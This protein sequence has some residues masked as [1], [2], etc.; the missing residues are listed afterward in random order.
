[1][2]RDQLENRL[3]RSFYERSPIVVAQQLLGKSLLRRV[4]QQWIGGRI[5]ETEAY[6]AAE[7]PASHSARGRTPRN[8]SMFGPPG[9]LYVYTIH[10]KYCLNAVTEAAGV[11]SAVLIRALEPIWGIKR[12]KKNRGVDDLRRLARGPAMLC[13]ALG[14]DRQQDG[15]DLVD[16][17]LVAITGSPSEDP[18]ISES[19]TVTS[20]PRIGI[21]QATE[22]QLRFFVDANWYVG[23]RASDHQNRPTRP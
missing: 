23:G 15:I 4:R 9:T 2:N 1:M 14:I 3:P 18:S 22:R 21:S 16:S 13:Q 8:A 17:D 20:S 6:L 11:G 10:A 5:V 7:D 19:L 12:M